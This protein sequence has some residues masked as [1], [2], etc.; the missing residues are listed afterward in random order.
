[1]ETLWQMEA[2]IDDM[3][4]QNMEYVFRR[5][6][7]LGVNDVWA[8]PVMMKK[9]RMASMLCV[10]CREELLD[11]AAEIIFAET[12]SIG[13]R[14]FPVQRRACGRTVQTVTVDG[15]P[16]RCKICTYGGTVTNISAEY[17][18]CRAAAA[19]TGTPLKMWQRKAK[20]EAYKQYGC[21]AETD[22]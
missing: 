16:I 9:C 7:D 5:L 11:K 13:V 21:S 6:L 4:P 12:T 18:D 19:Q 15:R 2:N 8:V 3:N 10:L 17:D 14:Y 22:H 1:M 20:E